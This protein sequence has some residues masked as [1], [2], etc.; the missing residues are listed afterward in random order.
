MYDVTVPTRASFVDS[1]NP[2]D[3][4]GD[5][6]ENGSGSGCED[7]VLV[8]AKDPPT[9]GPLLVVGNEVSGTTTVCAV[10]RD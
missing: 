2:R 5:P 6:A 3:F 7:L 9:R 4:T 1:V 10:T 8:A